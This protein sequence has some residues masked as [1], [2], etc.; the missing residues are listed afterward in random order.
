MAGNVVAEL[1]ALGLLIS[2]GSRSPVRLG[3]PI[4]VAER[5]F[6]RLFPAT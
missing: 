2:D 5:W 6:P 4:E 3:V 1:V